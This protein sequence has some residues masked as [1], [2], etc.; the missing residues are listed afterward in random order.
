MRGQDSRISRD[1]T[2]TSAPHGTTPAREGQ[3]L[4]NRQVLVGDHLPAAL[5]IKEKRLPHCATAHAVEPEIHLPLV[6]ITQKQ[7]LPNL[8]RGKC[9]L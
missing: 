8:E 5:C 7:K 2:L 9:Q 4:A 6:L 3:E 1:H